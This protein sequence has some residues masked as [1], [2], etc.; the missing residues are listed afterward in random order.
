MLHLVAYAREERVTLKMGTQLRHH[1][2]AGVDLTVARGHT[3]DVHGQR[4]LRNGRCVKPPGRPVTHQRGELAI[5]AA[6]RMRAVVGDDFRAPIGRALKRRE[7]IEAGNTFLLRQR[8]QCSHQ[9]ADAVVVSPSAI[10]GGLMS[11][12]DNVP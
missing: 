5:A 8:R 7:H 1:R 6:T 12:R 2:E 9:L 10:G 3:D 11:R 4:R